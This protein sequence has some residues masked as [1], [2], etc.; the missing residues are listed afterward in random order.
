MNTGSGTAT[1]RTK[2][3]DRHV[4]GWKARGRPRG[5]TPIILAV[6]L[7]L[8][9]AAIPTGKAQAAPGT[10]VLCS[11]DSSEGQANADSGNPSISADGRYVVFNTEASNLVAGDD[12]GF[13]DVFRKDLDTGAIV[14]CST[15]ASGNQANGVSTYATISATGKYVAF[16]SDATNLVAGDTNEHSDIFRKDL[17]TG[18]IVRCS[19]NASG[20]QANSDSSNPSISSDGRYVAFDSIAT[21]L[22]A[23]DT[24]TVRDIFHKDIDTGAIL[25]CSTDS[26]GNEGGPTDTF[27]YP[28]ISPD[29]RYVVFYS[30]ATTMVAGDTNGKY[31]IFRKDTQTNATI[32]CS[33]DSSGNQ[34]TGASY[35]PRISQGGRYVFFQSEATDLVAGD[36]N[37]QTDIFRKDLDTGAVMRCSTDSTG[38][39]A[40]DMSMRSSITPDGRYVTFYSYAT[41]LVADDT[42]GD[43]DVFLK[44]TQTGETLRCSTTTAGDQATGGSYNPW[45]SADGTFVAFE[46]TA[47]DLVAGDTNGYQ[48]I[49]R[50]EFT[51]PPTVTA[52]DP[53]CSTNEEALTGVVVTGTGFLDG[54]T[55]KLARTNL[56][57]IAATNVVVDSD[58]QI[59]CDLDLT[60]AATGTWDV[61]VTNPNT[62]EG[63]L[64]FGFR[65]DL[66]WGS[67]DAWGYNTYGQATSAAGSDFIA[68]SA[69][70]L[71]SLALRSDGSLAGL[72]LQ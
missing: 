63:T 55:V 44:D 43:S 54:A 20:D 11:T 8:M 23:G 16:Y 51:P 56:P 38:A 58:T 19:T 32:R 70:Y 25:R 42:N 29:G 67:L 12:N 66:G 57:D 13:T 59:T 1:R 24:N 69:G 5:V 60:G 50:K 28:A 36:T 37:S 53:T 26:S 41:N 14:R 18:A 7:A 17:D 22:V 4:P 35:A 10:V 15:D 47:A 40:D 52:I 3:S 33:T 46:S 65:V 64:M 2:R 34:V 68:V 39:Q 21:D 9:L 48:D 27:E 45:V 31:D 30:N 49:F 61:V 72:G 62:Q 71:H 6:L